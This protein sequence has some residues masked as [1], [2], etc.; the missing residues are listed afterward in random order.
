MGCAV[1]SDGMVA[2]TGKRPREFL[3]R[4]DTQL[5]QDSWNVLQEHR[6]QVGLIIFQR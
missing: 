6:E 4:E 5:V 1:S 2:A 3:Y